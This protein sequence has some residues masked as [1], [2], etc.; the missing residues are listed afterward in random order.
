MSGKKCRIV[1][2][3]TTLPGREDLIIDTCKSIVEQTIKPDVIYLTLPKIAR[4][5]NQPY[6]EMPDQIKSWCKIIQSDIDYGPVTKLYGGIAEES[7]PE[8]IIIS[9]DDDVIYPPNTFETLLEKSEMYPEMCICGSGM[10]VSRGMYFNS[11]FTNMNKYIHLNGFFGFI[12]PK[13][14]RKV[15]L[16]FGVSSVLYKRKFFPSL[17][18]CID[19]LFMVSLSDMDILCND[20]VLISGYMCKRGI[21]RMVFPDIPV[22]RLIESDGAH[23]EVALSFGGGFKLI[24]RMNRSIDKVHKLG[25]FKEYEQLGINES[26][27]TNG[28][29]ATIIFIFIVILLIVMWY[30]VERPVPVNRFRQIIYI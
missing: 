26:V 8:T 4:R 3:M 7:D 5:F 13:T 30:T 19:E 14:G 1:V 10:L 17:K 6:P 12:P 27:F 20:D 9:C 15:D 22:I 11:T 21:K 18:E 25:Y 24:N 28:I 2:T 23:P 16:I 29:F